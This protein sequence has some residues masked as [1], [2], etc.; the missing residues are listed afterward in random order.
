MRNSSRNLRWVYLGP[1]DVRT[2]NVV[3]DSILTHLEFVDCVWVV[4][5]E[6][7]VP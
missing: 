1:R 6:V 5:D 7:Y 4:H 3:S 2:M